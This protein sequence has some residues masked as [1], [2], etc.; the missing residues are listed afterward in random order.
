[1]TFSDIG[2]QDGRILKIGLRFGR[3]TRFI[4]SVA[5]SLNIAFHDFGQ[6]TPYSI[7]CF[8]NAHCCSTAV[9]HILRMAG[10]HCY[11]MLWLPSANLAPPDDSLFD[12]SVCVLVHVL[13]SDDTRISCRFLVH[14][15]KA[16]EQ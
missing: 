7:Q 6:M 9:L 11:A 15:T 4:V 10:L 1:M 5:N 14:K 16:I 3:I 13:T 2:K 8:F 12:L